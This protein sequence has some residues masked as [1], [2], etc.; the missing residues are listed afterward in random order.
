MGRNG[1][2]AGRAIGE[3]VWEEMGRQQEGYRGDSM[4]RQQEGYRGDSM[5]RNG[6]T[7]GRAMGINGKT[8]GTL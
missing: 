4:G 8:A 2:T 6:K 5:G 3:I 7:A 1:K